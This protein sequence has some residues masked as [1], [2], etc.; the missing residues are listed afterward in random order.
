MA[1]SYTEVTS[2]NWFSRIGGSIKGILFGIIIIPVTIVL[3]WWNE[4]R[5]VTTA[6]S[7]KEGAAAV[8]HVA[9]DKVDPAND[10]KLVH[11]TGD[12][13]ATGMV[14][15]TNYGIS[16]PALRIVRTEEIYQWVENTKTE[17][18]EKVGGSEE[19]TTTYTYEKKWV[20]EPVKSSEFKKPEGHTNKG[21]LIP[22]NANIAAGEVTLGVFDVPEDFVKQMGS[23]IK[24]AVTDADLARLPEDLKT[25]TKIQDGAFY[26]GENPKTPQVG[27]VRVSFEI[28]KPGTYSILAAQID[29][30]FEP[31]QTK[32]G[33]AI[34]FIEEGTVSAEAMFKN[35]AAANSMITWLVRFFGFLFM[36]FGFM[37]I[38]K[39]LSVL[40]SVIPFIGNIIGMGTG[41]ISFVLAGTISFLVIAIAWI[42]V[43]PLLGIAMLALAI[44]GF[45]YMRKLAAASKPATV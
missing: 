9:A 26:I 43:R 12:A 38:M 13:K 30:T 1:D 29:E 23:P 39:P 45:I 4:G 16:V 24:N 7:L 6:N 8:V 35:A 5:A 2:Q 20:D 42:F 37:A 40:G 18:K 34:N 10:K 21:D 27:D 41:L 25:G 14:E 11:V 15:D 19:T 3:L 31:Y 17:T 28:V 33:D 22:E 36:A 44:G 32:A